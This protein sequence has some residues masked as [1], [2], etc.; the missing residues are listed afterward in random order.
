MY[1]QIINFLTYFTYKFFT[2]INVLF[3]KLFIN[4]NIHRFLS[5]LFTN[6]HRLLRQIEF[7]RNT[8]TK[9]NQ[10]C[11]I[12]YLLKVN[13]N[14]RLYNIFSQVYRFSGYSCVTV[15]VYIRRD[16]VPDA[17][18]FSSRCHFATGCLLLT[19]VRPDP[20]ASR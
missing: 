6:H 4:K 2:Y 1:K 20:R 7:I 14:L 13:R 5:F 11:T 3:Y 8:E 19:N 12:L 9:E 10:N 15:W 16:I 17:N 18:K